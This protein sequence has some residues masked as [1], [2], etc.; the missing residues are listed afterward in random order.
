MIYS[1]PYFFLRDN[2]YL[3][4]LTNTQFK[5]LLYR[6]E[7][8]EKKNIN[9][10]INREIN[11]SESG[12]KYNIKKEILKFNKEPET[13]K[14]INKPKILKRNKTVDNG[15]IK[16]YNKKY[17]DKI[18]NEDLNKRLK[19]KYKN[20]NDKVE[21]EMINTITKLNTYKKKDYIFESNNKY[22]KSYNEKTN[23]NYFKPYSIKKN[24]DRL[25]REQ[26]FHKQ[27]FKQNTNNNEE[28]GIIL[29]YQKILEDVYK[30]E[31]Q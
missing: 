7:E 20:R 29:K 25:K 5:T 6:I 21:K 23:E 27:R 22:F 18:I 31:K 30:K 10:N 1:D 9:N 2:Q 11:E 4:K 13:I 12:E 16:F 15:I 3:Y 26:L 19:E 28:Q 17:I 14:I 8:E 24:N